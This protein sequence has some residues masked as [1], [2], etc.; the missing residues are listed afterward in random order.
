MK[1]MG[2]ASGVPVSAF[3]ARRDAAADAAALSERPT[4]GSGYRQTR[5]IAF[6]RTSS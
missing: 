2:R 3:A 5:S 1:R 6:T 4:I